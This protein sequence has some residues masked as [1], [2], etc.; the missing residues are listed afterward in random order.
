MACLLLC[1]LR[2]ARPFAIDANAGVSCVGRPLVWMLRFELGVDAP[3]AA[4]GALSIFGCAL[5]VMLVVHGA[6]VMDGFLAAAMPR[7]GGSVGGC[8]G[9]AI[10]IVMVGAV[11][12]LL[13]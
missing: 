10:C 12:L 4:A 9:G 7:G 5:L 2:R 3:A 6:G 8:R 1:S 13:V 11:L